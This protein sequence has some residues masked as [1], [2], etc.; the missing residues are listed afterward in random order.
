MWRHAQ[1]RLSI[2][3]DYNQ[4]IVKQTKRKKQVTKSKQDTEK[5]MQ[6]PK[7]NDLLD[8]PCTCW[9]YPNG[10][11]LWKKPCPHE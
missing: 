9:L 8:D 7:I 11:C 5:V 6:Q 4:S 10:S 3:D 2:L 1:D